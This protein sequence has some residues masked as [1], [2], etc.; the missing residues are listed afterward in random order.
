MRDN[1][2]E[3]VVIRVLERANQQIVGTFED[4]KAFGFLIP[5][6]VRIPNDVFIPKDNMNGAVAGHKVVVE[7][8]KFPEGRKS[9]EGEVVKI[10]GH[11]NDPGIDILSIIYKHGIK[12]D[13]P[14]EVL[15]AVAE[16]P[17]HVTEKDKEGRRDLRDK[18]IVTIDGADAKDL[19]D[20]VRVEKL[21]N[22][23]F[24]LGVYIADVTHYV[25]EGS[26]IDKEAH[27]RG[28]SVYL[29]DRVIPMNPQRLSNRICSLNKGEDRLAI[30][31][32]LEVDKRGIVVAHEIFEAV[33]RMAERMTYKDV[34]KILVDKDGATRK[35]FEALVPGFERMEELAAILRKK[36]MKR[37]AIDFDFKEAQVLV[38]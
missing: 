35:K 34:N 27:E 33:I 31:C 5:D 16:I 21:D 7:L 24:L 26:A 8:T 1:R 13:F 22:G 20:A 28:T 12:I 10:L 2:H 30:G 15:Q 18:T 25:T 14:D 38:D 11:K 36:R 29:V 4:N 6:D 3:G 9:A 37:G 32:E 17:D 19:D 23:N